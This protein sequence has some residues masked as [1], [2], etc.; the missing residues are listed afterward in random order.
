M[1]NFDERYWLRLLKI[2]LVSATNNLSALIVDL[3]L[4][5]IS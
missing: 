5:N 4:K 3:L 1:T 2:S